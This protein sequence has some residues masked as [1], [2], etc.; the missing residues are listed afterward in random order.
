MLSILSLLT[1]IANLFNFN[2]SYLNNFSGLIEM[3]LSQTTTFQR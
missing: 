3:S 1:S 2:D